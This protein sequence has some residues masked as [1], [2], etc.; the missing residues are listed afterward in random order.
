MSAKV[1]YN[2]RARSAFL[3]F[4]NHIHGNLGIS[5]VFSVASTT[6]FVTDHDYLAKPFIE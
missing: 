1:D 2:A 6:A 4:T 3:N 5:T